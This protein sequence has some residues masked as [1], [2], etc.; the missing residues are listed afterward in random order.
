ML[1]KVV[2][3]RLC[4]IVRFGNYIL[5]SRAKRSFDSSVIFGRCS[6]N[7]R[8]RA[9]NTLQH[10]AVCLL[11]YKLDAVCK[12]FKISFKLFK[13]F[14]LSEKLFTVKR[15]LI[16]FGFYNIAF[17]LTFLYGILF[18]SRIII[19]KSCPDDTV[20]QHFF[21]IRDYIFKRSCL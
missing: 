20:I 17:V 11:H 4:I 21:I 1:F 3:S 9:V 10:S 6:Y 16:G 13:H 12:A 15:K 8:N 18:L 19:K 5:H 7:S 14:S 2:Y